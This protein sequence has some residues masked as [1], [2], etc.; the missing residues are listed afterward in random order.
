MQIGKT[1]FILGILGIFV[2]VIIAL[3]LPVNAT[4]FTMA[5]LSIVQIVYNVL[6]I[7]KSKSTSIISFYTLF[8]FFSWFFHCG[9]IVKLA[10]DIPGSVPLDVARYADNTS[11]L[12]SFRFFFVS[13]S[14]ISA[15]MLFARPKQY[16]REIY[17]N[18]FNA[19]KSSK[20][21]IAL[22]IIPR[23]YID[24]SILLG[25]LAGGYQGVYSITFPQ[26]LQTI[27]FFFDAGCVIALLD[28]ENKKRNTL[29]WIILIYK[30]ITMSTGARQERIAFLIIWVFIFFY[31]SKEVH[32]SNVI[33]MTILAVLGIL[34]VN[35]IGVIRASSSISISEVFSSMFSNESS[36]VLGNMLG[37]FG[38]ALT[39]LAVTVKKVPIECSWGYGD[40]YLAGILSIVPTLANRLG[41][42]N[43][44][45][46]ISN[47]SGV[48]YFGGSYLG[49][50]YYNFSWFG[51]L[52][53]I[54]IGIFVS[55]A[56]N[57]IY[58]KDTNGNIT[59]KSIFS[60]I[61]MMSLIL[62]VRGYFT[63]MVQKLVWTWVLL[64]FVNDRPITFGRN[65]R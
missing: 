49:E 55:R 5:F 44:T 8:L 7:K 31:V 25:G 38:S 61:V 23:L 27:A 60:A 28:T 40:S 29:F 39:T 57:Y 26:I 64:Y 17:Q 24:I 58:E 16:N 34:L 30:C 10:F 37:E 47:L 19:K 4:Y 56:Q 35:S 12:N 52:A 53:C 14:M 41:L 11:I 65:A 3:L 63:D 45:M 1:D 59:K 54:V 18:K 42:G 6:V 22:G 48:T 33:M 2:G 36:N 43:A 15:G 20:V 50:L 62:F 21:L 32:L 51:S 9:Q 46:Y 13:Q